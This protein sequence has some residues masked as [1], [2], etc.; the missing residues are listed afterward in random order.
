MSESPDPAGLAEQSR[1]GSIPQDPAERLAGR[2]LLA[3]D[4]TETQSVLRHILERAGLEVE[5]VE[6]GRTALELASGGAFDVILMDMQMREPG[7]YAAARALRRR[8]YS[9]AVVALAAHAQSCDEEKCL[10]AGCDTYLSKPVNPDKLLQVVRTYLSPDRWGMSCSPT[11]FDV[12]PSVGYGEA[13]PSGLAQLTADYCRALPEKVR[14]I[15]EA[16]RE[17]NMLRVSELAHQLRG[18]AGMYGLPHISAAAGSVEDACRAG[19]GA[20][21]LD[22]LVGYLLTAAHR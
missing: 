21:Q 11:W 17:G 18:S 6:N 10:S 14:A 3:A 12:P 15:G 16:L 20:A 13:V 22:E 4:A 9:G 19:C 1:P 2:V 7:G 8:G 5:A